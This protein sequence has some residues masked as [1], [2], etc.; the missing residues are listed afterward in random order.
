MGVGY[1]GM[2]LVGEFEI[3]YGFLY[4]DVVEYDI[5]GYFGWLEDEEGFFGVDGF[6]DLVVVFV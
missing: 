2:N 5:D 1:V 4:F 3:V 6:M